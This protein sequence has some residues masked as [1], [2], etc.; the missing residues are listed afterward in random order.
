MP[1]VVG[2]FCTVADYLLKPVFVSLFNNILQPLLTLCWNTFT[3]LERAVQPVFGMFKSL[4]EVI[5]TVTG[6]LRLIHINKTKNH[7]ICEHLPKVQE[8]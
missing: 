6:S 3:M 4:G 8:A 1:V 7:C 5:A 2:T